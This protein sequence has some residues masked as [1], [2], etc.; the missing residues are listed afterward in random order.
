M[1][2]NVEDNELLAS[3]ISSG[4]LLLPIMSRNQKRVESINHLDDNLR[5]ERSPIAPMPVPL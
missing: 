3:Q 5:G 1:Q 2:G 4:T